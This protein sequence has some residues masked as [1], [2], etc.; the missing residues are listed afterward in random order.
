M[1]EVWVTM[2][3]SVVNLTGAFFV[4]IWWENVACFRIFLSVQDLREKRRKE[5]KRKEKG[6]CS[7]SCYEET[8]PLGGNVALNIFRFFPGAIV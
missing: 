2:H 6:S 5:K 1:K 7:E 8:R 4:Q 3:S